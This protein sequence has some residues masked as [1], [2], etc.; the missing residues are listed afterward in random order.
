MAQL[1]RL[2]FLDP[3]D[4]ETLQE[5]LRRQNNLD[6][7]LK[8]LCWHIRDHLLK[9]FPPA[10]AREITTPYVRLIGETLARAVLQ[11]LRQQHPR[12]RH[13]DDSI[14]VRYY[15]DRAGSL[16]ALAISHL[17][18]SWWRDYQKRPRDTLAARVQR[19]LPSL[20]VLPNQRGRS[21]LGTSYRLLFF[22]VYE[23]AYRRLKALPPTRGEHLTE[24]TRQRRERIFREVFC[25]LPQVEDPQLAR[26]L[27]HPVTGEI[28]FK[29]SSTEYEGWL[30][31]TKQEIALEIA[32]RAIKASPGMSMTP[33]YLRR[34][35][36]TLRKEARALDRALKR[37]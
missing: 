6:W 27:F 28:F 35:L 36:P 33:E 24:R 32:V 5:T 15:P 16:L 4:E 23:E 2:Y 31:L 26:R 25:D 1:R 10:D 18:E 29:I 19:R 22:M 21:V 37:S 20:R 7:L 12:D 8:L 14:L 17:D 34:I 30:F 9:A 13:R 11:K 3:S